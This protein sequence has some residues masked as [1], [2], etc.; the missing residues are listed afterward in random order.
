MSVSSARF[1]TVF[2]LSPTKALSLFSLFPQDPQ[3]VPP[4]SQSADILCKMLVAHTRCGL[5]RTEQNA[6][7][8]KKSRS[9]GN[10]C[11]VSCCRW[12][13]KKRADINKKRWKIQY[14]VGGKRRCVL[15]ICHARPN[16]TSV[17]FCI[18]RFCE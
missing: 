11:S 16:P 17:Y 1:E 5:R 14:A 3:Y 10:I 6:S 8:K 7:R 9:R 4:H 15:L 12:V 13:R 18:L 2:S